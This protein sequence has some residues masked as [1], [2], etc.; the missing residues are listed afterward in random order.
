MGA[1]QKSSVYGQ[2]RARSGHW[3]A[4]A[5]DPKGQAT[6]SQ[7]AELNEAAI[8]EMKGKWA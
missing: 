2:S 7:A 8:M 1:E 3:V 6:L 4:A 5:R